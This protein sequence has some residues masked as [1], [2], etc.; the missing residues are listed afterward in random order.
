[1]TKRQRAIAE[2]ETAYS[3]P[4]TYLKNRR[5]VEEVKKPQDTEEIKRALTRIKELNFWVEERRKKLK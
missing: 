1:M 2:D 3:T 4:V 5:T